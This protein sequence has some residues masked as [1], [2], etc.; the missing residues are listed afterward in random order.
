MVSLSERLLCKLNVMDRGNTTANSQTVRRDLGMCYFSLL[1]WLA[2]EVK[3]STIDICNWS[4]SVKIMIV[5]I[6]NVEEQNGIA[7]SA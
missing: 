2:D 4:E 1:A 3:R 7:T 6:W 5:I